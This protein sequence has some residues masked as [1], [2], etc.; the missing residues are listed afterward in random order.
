MS[1]H[2]AWKQQ[3]RTFSHRQKCL[4]PL[5][6]SSLTNK[7]RGQRWEST[8]GLGLAAECVRLSQKAPL[9]AAP[10]SWTRAVSC[11]NKIRQ[12]QAVLE[13][14]TLSGPRHQRR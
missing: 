2:A 11:R 10:S 7:G 13:V 12:H 3:C 14:M 6:C 4:Q 5:P 8:D 1:N 9:E